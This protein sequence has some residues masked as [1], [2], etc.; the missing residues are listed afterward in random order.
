M[1]KK[2]L[3]II[4]SF[5]ASF[6][7]FIDIALFKNMTN[8]NYRNFLGVNTLGLL[9]V[10][11]TVLYLL[12]KNKETK[13]NKL[14]FFLCILFSIF[15]IIGE[16]LETSGTIS[17]LYSNIATLM[18]S[19]IKLVGFITIFKIGFYY[20]DILISK[21]KNKE[22]K[23][24]N[25]YFKWYL[26]QLEKHP[27]RTS[28]VSILIMWSIYLIAFYPIVMSPDPSYQIIQYFNIPNKY[29]NWVIQA[30]PNVYM[31]SHHSVLH[32]YLLG[33]SIS[34]GRLILNDNFGLFIYTLLQTAVYS[35]TLAYTIKF[36]KN[37]KVSTK[38]CFIVLLI[39]MFVPM[40]GLYTMSANKDIF[41]T[42]F[43]IL[44]ILFI[45]DYVKNYKD[46]KITIPF[47]IK[48]FIIILLLCLFRNNGL[49]IAIMTL[50]FLLL[51][52]KKNWLRI[53]TTFVVTIICVVAFNSILIPA[54]GISKGSIR[55]MLSIPFQQTARLATYYDKDISTSDKKAI[56]KILTYDTLKKR[57]NPKLADPVKNE[58]NKY[59]ESE[60]LKNYFVA[61][62]HGLIKHPFVY[63]NA[64]L[65]NTYGYF[66][67]NTHNWY[68]YGRFKDTITKD[69]LVDYS[70]NDST[71]LLRTTLYGWA[72]IF[73]YI[74]LVGSIS[75]IALG[76]W[77]MLII[78]AYLITNK[79][80]K[81]LIT[82][83]PMY[84]SWI[85]CILSPANTYFRYAMPYL[86]VL[87]VIIVLLLNVKNIE[88]QI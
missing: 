82:L 53:G 88:E 50:P 21:F 45:F 22:M 19:I 84:G 18:V 17:I 55:E 44:F 64:T 62:A 5:C 7:F 71:Q 34:L 33:W 40:F 39:Y 59:T 14:K 77:T 66:Y 26:E 4:L 70:W 6:C 31:T 69:G 25:K 10:F 11:V 15:M 52:S 36:A 38:A 74:P 87:P 67:P 8:I 75:N 58:Y 80:K 54:L 76:F 83:I 3:N 2:A 47:M 57:Y 43:M 56:D 1:K 51:F 46:K 86:F 23:T 63:I 28:L 85:F 60:D 29:I 12:T 61:W 73:P 68:V 48:L 24:K 79:N 37:N 41:Y 42:S 81:Y 72:N 16:A 30:D 78:S 20:L 9:L 35:S 32:T 49:Y 13:I 65:N 27:F